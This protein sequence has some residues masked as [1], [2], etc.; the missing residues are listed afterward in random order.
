MFNTIGG[1]PTAIAG[2][3]ANVNALMAKV[4]G[5]FNTSSLILPPSALAS[6]PAVYQT[7]ALPTLITPTAGATTS[8]LDLGLTN[9]TVASPPTSAGSLGLAGTTSGVHLALTARTG[10][11][12]ILGNIL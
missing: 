9:G 12:L 11:G 3:S 7:L 8:I 5:V 4:I 10:E 2:V 1:A 6:L